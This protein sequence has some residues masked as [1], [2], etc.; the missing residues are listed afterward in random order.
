MFLLKCVITGL[1]N[2]E[3]VC[4]LK[5]FFIATGMLMISLLIA[6]NLL[7]SISY[8]MACFATVYN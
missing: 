6:N 7:L 5:V 1:I 2:A 3:Y 8:I 4:Q